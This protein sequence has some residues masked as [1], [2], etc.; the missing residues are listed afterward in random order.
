MN[1]SIESSAHICRESLL[2]RA[3]FS[4]P[5][6]QRQGFKTSSVVARASNAKIPSPQPPLPWRGRG[7]SSRGFCM[8]SGKNGCSPS[9]TFS[10][11]RGLGGEGTLTSSLAKKPCLVDCRCCRSP[12][13]FCWLWLF[14]AFCCA[15]LR[16]LLLH[17]VDD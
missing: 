3:I 13:P 11:E 17:S 12:W 7:A 5:P 4:C 15:S 2:V 8:I 9:P 1:Y 6:N 14:S 10:W 16:Q